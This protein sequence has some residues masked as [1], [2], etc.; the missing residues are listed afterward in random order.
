VS[1]VDE[2]EQGRGNEELLDELSVPSLLQFRLC[3]NFISAFVDFI[4]WGKDIPGVL[5]QIAPDNFRNNFWTTFNPRITVAR[6]CVLE[7]FCD[8]KRITCL[9]RFC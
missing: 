1:A 6:E 3:C 7:Q 9:E 4:F 2:D 5:Q 8:K